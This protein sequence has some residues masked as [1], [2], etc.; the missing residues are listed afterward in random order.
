M[1]CKMFHCLPRQLEE[2]DGKLIE[3][4][5]VIQNEMTQEE[6]ERAREMEVKARLSG[7]T[8]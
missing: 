7:G 6:M 5:I 2:E 3:K 4:F 8:M 1:L